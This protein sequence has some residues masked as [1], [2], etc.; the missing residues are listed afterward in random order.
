MEIHD[1]TLTPLVHG[2]DNKRM[3]CLIEE[4]G[5]HQRPPFFLEE[6]DAFVVFSDGSLQRG[7]VFGGKLSGNELAAAAKRK[8]TTVK[9]KERKRLCCVE[10]RCDLN[11]V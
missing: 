10:Q 2:L 6:M 7:R 1:A 9:N 8:V 3:D 4:N 5:N 11:F